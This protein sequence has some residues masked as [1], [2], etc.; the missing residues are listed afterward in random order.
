MY[1]PVRRL[2]GAQPIHL[3]F[4]GLLLDYGDEKISDADKEVTLM[5]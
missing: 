2:N 5:F 3:D 1:L 4:T